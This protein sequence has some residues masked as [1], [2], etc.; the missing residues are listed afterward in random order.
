[1]YTKQNQLTR[2][3]VSETG[4]SEV[5]SFSLIF[6]LII[7]SIGLIYTQAYPEL[8]E[9]KNIEVDRNIERS[10]SIVDDNFDTVA[11]G[12]SPS[13]VTEL[14]VGESKLAVQE[15]QYNITYGVYQNGNWTNYTVQAD[16]PTYETPTGTEYYY[17]NGAVVHK[18]GDSIYFVERP[19]H[20]RSNRGE[21]QLDLIGLNHRGSQISGGT[22]TV[23]AVGGNGITAILTPESPN[24]THTAT[25]RMDTPSDAETKFWMQHFSQQKQFATCQQ[26]ST[27]QFTCETAP[28]TE[29]IIDYRLVTYE[30]IS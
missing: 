20:I 1:M 28:Y 10:L 19:T 24:K 27:T 7:T 30:Y 2:F 23:T 5:L 11:S 22:H 6:A 17:L 9:E 16:V 18:S 3:D 26:V 12:Q 25:L 15:D 21:L 8:Q 14:K 4:V 13:R 29:I